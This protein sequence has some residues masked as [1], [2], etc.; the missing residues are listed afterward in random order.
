[1]LAFGQTRVGAIGCYGGVNSLGVSESGNHGL[2]NQN[3]VTDRAM[4]ARGQTRV[5]TIGC[6]GGIVSL[7]V[8]QGGSD[9]F[10]T[11]R[12]GL[13]I[14][15]GSIRAGSMDTNSRI[16]FNFNR[17]FINSSTIILDSVTLIEIDV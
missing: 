12:T 1:M 3:L 4:L 14:G 7:G 13:C 17:H 11:N 2:G 10:I 16:V 5:G 6:H 15:A 8:S 9:L